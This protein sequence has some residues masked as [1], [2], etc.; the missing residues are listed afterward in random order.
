MQKK[1]IFIHTQSEKPTV[2]KNAH[3]KIEL[4]ECNGMCSYECSITVE[5]RK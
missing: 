1:Y 4:G 3:D 2:A 5:T